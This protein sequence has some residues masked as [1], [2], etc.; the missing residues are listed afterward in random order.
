MTSITC[1]LGEFELLLLVT[2]ILVH[3]V[4]LPA[5]REQCLQGIVHTQDEAPE[6]GAGS[7]P[8]MAASKYHTWFLSRLKFR[9]SVTSPAGSTPG[10]L[11]QRMGQVAEAQK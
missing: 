8:S 10:I 3:V 4:S 7:S 9:E 11:G 5:S 2:G 1:A 6:G